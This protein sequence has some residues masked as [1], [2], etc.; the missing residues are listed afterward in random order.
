MIRYDPGLL[1]IDEKIATE[2]FEKRKKNIIRNEWLL[3]LH[4]KL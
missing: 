4:N 2:R 3:F 1:R